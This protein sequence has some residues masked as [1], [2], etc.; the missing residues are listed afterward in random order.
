MATPLERAK[1]GL[2]WRPQLMRSLLVQLLQTLFYDTSKIRDPDV[3]GY[4]WRRNSR[5]SDIKITVG[6]RLDLDEI[7]ESAELV[8]VFGNTKFRHDT[9][10][11]N[12]A[13]RRGDVETR[14]LIHQT[15]FGIQCVGQ[16]EAFTMKLSSAVAF[17]LQENAKS[18]KAKYDLVDFRVGSI[19]K[20][21]QNKK[22]EFISTLGLTLAGGQHTTIDINDL[23]E[24][25]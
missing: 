19:S 14:R 25:F 17:Q 24:A 4:T 5:D 10:E 1:G 3:S 13:E 7:D 21:S 23:K 6:G 12:L 18:I 20:P 8:V 2:G 15:G 16:S 11:S 9:D 22:R